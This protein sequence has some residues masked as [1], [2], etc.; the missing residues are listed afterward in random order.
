MFV[1]FFTHEE[2]VK[3]VD[4]SDISKSPH[5]P[6]FRLSR[7]EHRIALCVHCI[8]KMALNIIGAA[9]RNA[10]L[11]CRAITAIQKYPTQNTFNNVT[12]FPSTSVTPVRNINFMTAVSGEYIWK[13]T[14][15]TS[16]AGKKRGRAKGR[17]SG[18][19]RNTNRFQNIGE[20]RKQLIL[21]GLNVQLRAGTEALQVKRGS[22][23]PAWYV[24]YALLLLLICFC[25]LKTRCISEQ[26]LQIGQM[27]SFFFLE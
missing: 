17:G 5:N 4:S 15:S 14:T 7:C 10:S 6:T 23:D 25:F 9:L 16:N 11:K 13:S 12:K 8:S 1:S 22:D 19:T 2:R 18:F 3:R 24:C 26:A 20:G 27:Q 21:P